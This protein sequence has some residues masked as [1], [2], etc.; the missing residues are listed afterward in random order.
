[1]ALNDYFKMIMFFL[2]KGSAKQVFTTL[3]LEKFAEANDQSPNA[4]AKDI[5]RCPFWGNLEQSERF[6]SIWLNPKLTASEYYTQGNMYAE[7]VKLGFGPMIP[8][9]FYLP[10]ETEADLLTIQSKIKTVSISYLNEEGLCCGLFVQYRQDAPHKWIIAQSKNT[11]LSPDLHEIMILTPFNP[12]PFCQQ[13]GATIS[14]SPFLNEEFINSIG[15]KILTKFIKFIIGAD[16]KINVNAK[17]FNLF[18][19]YLSLEKHLEENGKL[20]QIIQERFSEFLTNKAFEILYNYNQNPQPRQILDCLNEK[21]SLYELITNYPLNGDKT[22]DAQ[23]LRIMVFLDAYG[24][25]KKQGLR[26][27]KSFVRGLNKI[28]YPENLNFL[29]ESLQ[30]QQKIEGLQFLFKT[31]K[32]RNYFEQFIEVSEKNDIWSKLNNLALQRWKFPEDKFCHALICKV[33]CNLP[34]ISIKDLLLLKKLRT[35]RDLEEFFDPLDFADFI[36]QNGVKGLTSLDEIQAYF[37]DLLLRYKDAAAW[38]KSPLSQKLLS[39][40]G[41]RYIEN[42]QDKRLQEYGFC[43]EPEEIDACIILHQQGIDLQLMKAYIKEPDFAYFVYILQSY[44]LER[45]LPN[46]FEGNTM[47]ALKQIASL[48]NYSEKLA[49]LFLVVQRQLKSDEYFAL[50]DSFI[51]HPNLARLIIHSHEKGFTA[52]ELKKLAFDPSM[53]RAANLLQHYEVN[54]NFKN[55]NPFACQTLL[56]IGE[57]TLTAKNDPFIKIYL[58]EALA[59]SLEFFADG[60]KLNNGRSQLKFKK[61]I[62]VLPTDAK[63][64]AQLLEKLDLFLKEQMLVFEWARKCDISKSNLLVTKKEFADELAFA[65]QL[66]TEK[67][68]NAE[69]YLSVCIG[70]SKLP[71]EAKANKELT[72]TAINALLYCAEEAPKEPLISF[73]LLL[74]NHKLA[75]AISSAAAHKLPSRQLLNSETLINTEIIAA[76][77]KLNRMAITNKNCFE[78]ALSENS[79][80]HDFRLLLALL[81]AKAEHSLLEFIE[82]SLDERREK[83]V[84]KLPESAIKN[85]AYHLDDSLLLINRLRTLDLNN[86]VIDFLVKEDQTSRFFY[87]TVRKIEAESELI[88]TRLAK[89]HP[90]K[91]L[92]L[93]NLEVEYRKNLY[94]ALYDGLKADNSGLQA[95]EKA[96]ILTARIKEAEKA[97]LEPLKIEKDEC[98]RWIKAAFVNMATI[99]LTIITF[100]VGWLLHHEHYRKTGDRFFFTSTKSEEGYKTI[101]NETLEEAIEVMHKIN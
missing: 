17:H 13:S 84:A 70:F 50:I 61:N 25:N 7:N 23:Q 14:S 56:F 75:R 96:A 57:L 45:H 101:N 42:P 32:F 21:S 81:P 72:Q 74:Q 48:K 58:K 26:L 51:N 83:R 54:F 3:G 11:N 59:A 85:L 55:L 19:Q 88:R 71:I 78:L 12:Q 10:N 77:N 46:L 93:R 66:L 39:S 100:G 40:I 38:R 18:L 94:L 43:T 67:N 53:H 29:G 80:G 60:F 73:D 99:A 92:A 76:L 20:I 91:F 33:L 9:P 86:E 52:K 69:F 89:E 37:N 82:R 22:I 62:P 2:I 28:L 4:I 15:D 65:F 41:K 35:N 31:S 64:T 87:K 49:T 36:T 63:E 6:K 90:S 8:T 27:N 5:E 98:A 44:G 30:D 34:E 97:I 95:S 1:M 68:A 79:K 24:L 16:G 47:L